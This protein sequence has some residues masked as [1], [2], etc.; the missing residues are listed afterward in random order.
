MQYENVIEV[1]YNWH[2]HPEHGC[3]WG[4]YR[5]GEL[6]ARFKGGFVRCEDIVVD[7]E[8]GMHAIIYFEDGTTEHQWNINK[9][10]EAEQD[11]YDHIKKHQGGGEAPPLPQPNTDQKKV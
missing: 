5:I 3:D 9:I 6:Y 2:K 1:H 4:Y 10:I 7:F 11:V 8:D